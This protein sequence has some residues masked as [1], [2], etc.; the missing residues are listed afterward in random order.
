MGEFNSAKWIIGIVIY[1][2]FF[3][4]VVLTLSSTLSWANAPDQYLV[5]N[6][7]GFENKTQPFDDTPSCSGSGSRSMNF[8]GNILCNQLNLDKN[9]FTGC[10]NIGGCLWK[11]D[12]SL[13]NIT[14]SGKSCTGTVDKITESINGSAGT[15]CEDSLGL[16][17]EERCV[18]YGC[19][20]VDNT[21]LSSNKAN[22]VSKDYSFIKVFKT[23][24][25]IITFRADIGLG[26]WSWLFGLFFWIPFVMMLIAIYYSLPFLH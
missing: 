17:T 6:D 12:T 1:Y 11:N 4:L 5:F 14:I 24:F 19:E 16:Q 20:W 25:F 26:Q 18:L 2:I 7:P 8:L 21:Q 22:L 10:N 23:V 15:Y 13:F 3:F 9:D